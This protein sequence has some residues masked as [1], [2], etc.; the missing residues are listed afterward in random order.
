MFGCILVKKNAVL[1]LQEDYEQALNNIDSLIAANQVL[2][3]KYEALKNKHMQEKRFDFCYSPE[4]GKVLIK[5][6]FSGDI[7]AKE[8]TN[9]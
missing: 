8:E 5:D 7:Y 2:N 9:D 1:E 6:L 3:D 4:T